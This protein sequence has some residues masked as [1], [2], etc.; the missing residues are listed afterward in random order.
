[1]S[2]HLK[3]SNGIAY[4]I[5]DYSDALIE[6]VWS[7]LEEHRVE[8]SKYEDMKLNPNNKVYL[9]LQEAGMVKIITAREIATGKIVGYACYIIQPNL[10]YCDFLY[11]NQDLFYVTQEKRGSRIAVNLLKISE[12]VLKEC[13]VSIIAQHAK[14]TNKFGKLL[15]LSG[16]NLAEKIY[17]KRID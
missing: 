5:E 9:A 11:A 8:L 15:E 13:N 7:T 17:H 1:M 6:E 16:Y 10:H 2:K 14:L 3:I 4:S 12:S